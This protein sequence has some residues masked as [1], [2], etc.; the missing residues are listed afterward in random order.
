[1]ESISDPLQMELPSAMD[2]IVHPS[3]SHLRWSPSQMELSSAMEFIAD[4]LH[5]RWRPSQMRDPSAMVA[6]RWSPSQRFSGKKK[7]RRREGFSG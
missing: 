6:L 3:L 5:L 1:M 4:G 2:F 7:Q